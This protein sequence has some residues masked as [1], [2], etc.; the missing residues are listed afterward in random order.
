MRFVATSSPELALT[1][2][3][4]GTLS[5]FARTQKAF[6]RAEQLTSVHLVADRSS[7]GWGT[8]REA[9]AKTEGQNTVILLLEH[10]GIAEGNWEQ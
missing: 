6:A 7:C 2:V 3:C 4:G 10:G 5:H 8:A 9:I 1:L